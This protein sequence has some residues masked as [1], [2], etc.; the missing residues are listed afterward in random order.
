MQRANRNLPTY[1]AFAM[2]VRLSYRISGAGWLASRRGT[3]QFS[4]AT[5]G[6][7]K[8]APGQFFGA[9]RRSYPVGYRS[10]KA[11]YSYSIVGHRRVKMCNNK[12]QYKEANVVTPLRVIAMRQCSFPS[13]RQQAAWGDCPP[14]CRVM[15]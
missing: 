9:V 8:E 2:L 6:L 7:N 13:C 14:Y 4:P 1:R 15:Y 12:V 5:C 3:A 10:T 11:L